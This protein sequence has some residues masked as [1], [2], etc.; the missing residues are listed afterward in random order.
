MN[1]PTKDSADIAAQM[2]EDISRKRMK[3]E[4]QNRILYRKC[5]NLW[6]TLSGVRNIVFQHLTEEQK[7]HIKQILNDNNPSN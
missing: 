4:Y 7:Q 3:A 2:V 6:Q 1:A 5:E